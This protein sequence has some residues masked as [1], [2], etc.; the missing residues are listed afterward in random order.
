[1]KKFT[2]P[3]LILHMENINIEKGEIGID[4][5]TLKGERDSY[6]EVGNKA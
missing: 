3:W 2:F 1:M 4:D 6:L 5:E